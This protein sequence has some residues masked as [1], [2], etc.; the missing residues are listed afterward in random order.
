[1]PKPLPDPGDAPFLEVAVSSEAHCLVTGNIK[2][3]P[4]GCRS[5]VK[6]LFEFAEFCVS[7][8]FAPVPH[9]QVVL[10]IP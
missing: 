4:R 3:F 1:L 6:V 10:S 8:V 7:E 2:H 5:G 9:R